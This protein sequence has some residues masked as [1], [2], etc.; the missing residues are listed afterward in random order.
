MKKVKYL[1]FICILMLCIASGCDR[2]E[3]QENKPDDKTVAIVVGDYKVMLDE[4]KYY[5]YNSQA[6]YE[7]YFLSE[8]KEINWNGYMRDN[9]IW[10]DGVKGFALSSMSRREFFYGL[11]DKYNVSFTVEEKD[12]IDRTVEDFFKESSDIIKNKISISKERLKYVVEKKEIATKVEDII[13]A[14]KDKEA[15]KM[16]LRWLETS[17][18]RGEECWENIHFKDHIITKEDVSKAQKIEGER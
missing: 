15:D 4:A 18:C 17:V 2:K 9:I 14:A 16:Y 12:K 6:T 11:R 5:V 8:G 3:P 7:L 1:L 10:E 13:N